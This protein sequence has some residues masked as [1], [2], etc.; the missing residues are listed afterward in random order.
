MG[1]TPIRKIEEPRVFVSSQQIHARRQKIITLEGGSTKGE[2]IKKITYRDADEEKPH[3]EGQTESSGDPSDDGRNLIKKPNVNSRHIK[4]R[5][6]T[7]GGEDESES[8]EVDNEEEDKNKTVKETKKLEDQEEEMEEDDAEDIEELLPSGFLSLGKVIMGYAKYIRKDTSKARE[9]LGRHLRALQAAYG[10]A[11]QEIMTM[12]TQR[13]TEE[14]HRDGMSLMQQDIAEIKETIKEMRSAP[15]GGRASWAGVVAGGS[16]AGKVSK[17]DERTSDHVVI[18]K[19]KNNLKP[20]TMQKEVEKLL[21][22]IKNNIMIKRVKKT[23]TNDLLIE[24]SNKSE[25][26][27]IIANKKLNKEMEVTLPKKILPKLIIYDV[28]RT[29]KKEEIEQRILNTNLREMPKDSNC[30][31]RLL[32]QTGRRE[33]EDTHW[34]AEASSEVWR[35]LLALR[36]IYFGM[37]S[38][39]VAEFEAV[40]RCYNCQKFGHPKKFCRS[41]EKTCGHCAGRGHDMSECKRKNE[42]RIC[43][44]CPR[45]E[46]DDHHVSSK[47]CKK[48]I[49]ALRFQRKRTDY[50]D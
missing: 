44:N 17:S 47:N 35:R 16:A 43:A 12:I 1:K 31:L 13:K 50:G 4:E 45:G 7:D 46:D 25:V 19:N 11:T 29:A 15:G 18:I 21:D 49:E 24:T 5:N 3:D 27:K 2:I 36:W 41:D 40:T 48:Y 20:E 26:D 32:F 33:S 14:R 22:P 8:E 28:P 30:S 10:E 37:F 23:K 9:A 34:V 42:N 39:K 6:T 38:C